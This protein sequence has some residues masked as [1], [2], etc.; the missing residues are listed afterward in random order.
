MSVHVCVPKQVEVVE[1]E[2]TTVAR[3]HN[4]KHVISATIYVQQ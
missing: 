4:S 2:E 1:P 3:K